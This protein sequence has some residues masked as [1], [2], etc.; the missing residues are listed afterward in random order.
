MH[1]LLELAFDDPAAAQ[2]QAARVVA[3]STDPVALSYAHQSL[4]IVL[5]ESGQVT[6]GLAEL[7]KALQ[8]ARRSSDLDPIVMSGPPTQGPWS[9]QGAQPPGSDS[10]RQRWRARP[11]SSAR[12]SWLAAQ[13]C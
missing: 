8:A 10:S 12:P 6:D 13:Q 2:V 4:G 7:R 9:W 3:E 11:T 1:D 5:R